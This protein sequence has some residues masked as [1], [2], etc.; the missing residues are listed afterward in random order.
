MENVTL[1]DGIQLYDYQQGIVNWM[2]NIKQ[3]PV[4]GSKGGVLFVDMG[5]GKTFTSLEYLR[6]C[7]SKQSLII[8]SKILIGE[9]LNQIEKFYDTKPSVFVLHPD[10]NKLKNIT[11]KYLSKF[12]IV[13]TTYHTVSAGN[14]H[15]KDVKYSDKFFIKEGSRYTIEDYDRIPSILYKKGKSSI[16]NI[17]WDNIICD[18]CQTI[19]N[20]RTSFFQSIYSIPTRHIFG[21]SGTPIKNNIL[22]FVAMLKFMK[23]N[24]YNIPSKWKK[25]T[26]SHSLFSLYKNVDMKWPM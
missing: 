16:Y 18:E 25:D 20:W 9:W 12:D 23:V 5:L 4:C 6:Q 19:T 2:E 3:N 24:G 8:C 22:E 11:S 21:L 1:K 15:S 13:I 14:K 10:Y 7:K 26:I 17:L